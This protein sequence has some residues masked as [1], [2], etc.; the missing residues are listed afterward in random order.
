MV[1]RWTHVFLALLL[2]ASGC[3]KKR[4]LPPRGSLI[5]SV[6]GDVQSMVR[7]LYEGDLAKVLD[8]THPTILK[9]LGGREQAMALLE[10]SMSPLLERG[11]RIESLSFPGP[12]EFIES[13]GSVFAI[14]PTLSVMAMGDQRVESL[15]FQF[16][17]LD[18]STDS[19][20]Y[21]E[22]S[23]INSGNVRSLFPDFPDGYRFPETYRRRL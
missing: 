2:F 6:Q 9:V 14:V 4:V 11:M 19:W 22:G 18:A 16:G 10:T 12:P 3:T 15:N 5:A 23:R 1:D 8:F 17:V 20:R 13:A 7:A 21:A